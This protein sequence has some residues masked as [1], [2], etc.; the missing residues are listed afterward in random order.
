MV[1]VE[2]QAAGL[3]V[4]ASDLVPRESVVIP[5]AMRFHS[6]DE[7]AS[8]W[9]QEALQLMSLPKPDSEMSNSAV[10]DSAF[11]IENSARRLLRLY[12]GSDLIQEAELSGRTREA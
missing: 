12:A 4:L 8:G 3:R 2:A 5:E 9:A 11:S 6:L 10:S 1:A 7:S